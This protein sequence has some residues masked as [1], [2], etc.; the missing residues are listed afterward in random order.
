MPVREI[1]LKF[2]LLKWG[3]VHDIIATVT[4]KA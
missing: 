3:V 1:V 2:Y 4:A